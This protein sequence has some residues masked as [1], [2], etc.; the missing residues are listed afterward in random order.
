MCRIIEF[1]TLGGEEIVADH[2]AGGGDATHA[3]TT[4]VEVESDNF[5]L[6]LIGF[7]LLRLLVALAL[8]FVALVRLVVGIFLLFLS[9][10]AEGIL[11][12][13]GVDLIPGVGIES[14]QHDIALIAPRSVALHAIF[15]GLV[16]DG[17]ATEH[18][19]GIAIA[20][21]AF[22]QVD[23]SAAICFN[24]CHVGVVPASDADIADQ[25]PLAVRT[26]FEGHIAV[27]I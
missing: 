7:S 26:P 27:G 4:V 24:G 22:G 15:A 16:G 10:F 25:D 11:L 19:L 5:G 8:L 18:P 17:F 23:H 13:G 9:L 6:L 3:V 12:F 14:H 1:I 20:I 21:A 2:G